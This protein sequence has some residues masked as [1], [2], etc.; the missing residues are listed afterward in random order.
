MGYRFDV[1][2]FWALDTDKYL[3]HTFYFL[4]YLVRQ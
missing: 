2:G 1:A 3:F 4:I